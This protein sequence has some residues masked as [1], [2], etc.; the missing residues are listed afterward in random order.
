VATTTIRGWA[1]VP[2]M[3]QNFTDAGPFDGSPR[4]GDIFITNGMEHTGLVWSVNDDGSIISIDGNWQDGVL[5]QRWHPS[6]LEGFCHP[7]YG[8]AEPDLDPTTRELIIDLHAAMSD[9]KLGTFQQPRIDRLENPIVRMATAMGP[10]SSS[11]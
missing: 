1:F 11:K 2:F 9:E 7:P 10:K 5:S 6:E 8:P 4:E 3:T